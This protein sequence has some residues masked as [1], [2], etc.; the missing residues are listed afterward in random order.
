MIDASWAMSAEEFLASVGLVGVSSVSGWLVGWAGWVGW[1]GWLVGWLG[2]LELVG[3]LL[4]KRPK[5]GVLI[6]TEASNPP[7]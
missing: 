5:H 4:C 7:E 1:V 6:Y 2:W 3:C